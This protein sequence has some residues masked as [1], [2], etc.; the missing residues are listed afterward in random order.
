VADYSTG[1]SKM[2]RTN[3]LLVAGGVVGAFA[4]VSA[5]WLVDWHGGAAKVGAGPGTIELAGAFR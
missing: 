3:V 1:V 4:A 2:D 5:V